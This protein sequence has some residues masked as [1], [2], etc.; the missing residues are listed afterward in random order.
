MLRMETSDSQSQLKRRDEPRGGDEDVDRDYDS[1]PAD[2]P[3]TQPFPWPDDT[4][5]DVPE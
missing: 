5:V 2:P 3:E 4:E 1:A